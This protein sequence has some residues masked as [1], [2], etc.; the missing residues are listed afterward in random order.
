MKKWTFFFFFFFSCRFLHVHFNVLSVLSVPTSRNTDIL[1]HFATINYQILTHMGSKDRCN[2]R[3][4]LLFQVFAKSQNCTS[5][6]PL[7]F[8]ALFL[9]SESCFGA[10]HSTYR[11][12][13]VIKLEW[14]RSSYWCD[15]VVVVVFVD[16]DITRPR[17]I[18]LS[19]LTMKKKNAMLP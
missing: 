8:L 4:N 16:G 9:A 6:V 2:L 10:R 13:S 12:S 5:R 11:I 15:T 14:L 3:T 17:A 19:M 1:S 18:P 7:Q